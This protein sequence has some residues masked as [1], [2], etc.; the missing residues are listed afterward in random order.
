MNKW[1]LKKKCWLTNK[2]LLWSTRNSGPALC[3]SLDGRG[4]WGRKDTYGWVPSLFTS[5]S[6]GTIN[7]WCAVLGRSAVADSLRP[8]GLQPA[9]L[10]C[11]WGCSRQYWSG[12]HCFLQVIFLMQGLNLCLQH[13]RQILYCWV[14]REARVVTTHHNLLLT[15][16]YF[17][18]RC[19]DIFINSS[20]YCIY[21][22]HVFWTTS[23]TSHNKETGLRKKYFHPKHHK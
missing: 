23:F 17:L 20:F 8:H 5:D 10:L 13:C 9:R 3:G 19:W 16:R 22:I 21:H 11:P 6:H 18:F 15:S 1:A 14:T 4:V 12:C 7:W 2:D